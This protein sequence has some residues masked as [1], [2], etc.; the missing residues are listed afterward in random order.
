[1]KKFIFILIVI[2][3]YSSIITK[4]EITN[5]FPKDYICNEIIQNDTTL[6]IQI[7]FPDK[8]S[9][10]VGLNDMIGKPIPEICDTLKARLKIGS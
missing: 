1:M 6:F 2:F 3:V 9:E 7:T 8:D 10:G 5:Q 4:Q